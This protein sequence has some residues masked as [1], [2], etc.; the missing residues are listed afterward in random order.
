[1]NVFLRLGFSFLLLLYALVSAQGKISI[2][3]STFYRSYFTVLLTC[4]IV[5]V[6]FLLLSVNFMSW[7]MRND[8]RVLIHNVF[9]CVCVR[10]CVRA[11][12]RVCVCV[13]VYCL[14]PECGAGC[15]HGFCE[16]SGECR[17][18]W[19]VRVCVCVCVWCVCA[20]VRVCV[21]VCVCVC[22]VCVCVCVCVWC[23]WCGVGQVKPYVMGTK[24]PH[25]DWQYPQILVRVGTFFGPHEETSL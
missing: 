2:L 20:R 11:C 9:V 21:C 13:C 19:C 6:A 16:Q 25:K 15:H 10:A 5:S 23:L 17:C 7:D 14:G 8:R 22:V 4:I 1:M 12:V 24:C 18:V 3:I